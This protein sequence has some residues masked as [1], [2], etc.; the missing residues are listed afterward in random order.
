MLKTL[1]GA[2]A[3]AILALTAWSLSAPPT[4]LETGWRY[5]SQGGWHHAGRLGQLTPE[6]RQWATIAWRYFQNNTQPDTGLVN[7][8]DNYPLT[9]PAQMGDTLVA[10]VAAQRLG[11]LEA[12]EFDRRLSALLATLSRLPLN[13]AGL[14]NRYYDSQRLTMVNGARQ[15]A[16]DGWSAG[17][18]AR[19]LLGLRLVTLA[20]PQYGGFIDRI[21]MGWNFCPMLT[22]QGALQDG[23]RRQNRW[24][25][26]PIA[27]LAQSQYAAAAMGLW[28]FDAPLS[29]APPYKRAIIGPNPI[30]TADRDPRLGGGNLSV[31]S[32]PYLLAGLEFNW[33]PPGKASLT[34]QD[35]RSRAQSVYQAQAWRWQRDGI[36][37]A[38]ADYALNRAP[39]RVDNAVFANGYPWNVLTEGGEYRPELALTATRALFGLWVLWDSPYTDA[40]MQ[41]GRWPRDD[42]RGWYEGRFERSGEYNPVMTLSTNAMVLESLL[43]KQNNGPLIDRLPPPGYLESQLREPLNWPRRCLPQEGR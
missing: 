29:A 24:Q 30:A 12:A 3:I 36:L 21:V 2:A 20:A 27:N 40:L 19:L 1:I 17:D 28:G 38:R 13:G 18:I 9:T 5:L 11:L 26:R 10:L 39:W 41:L 23:E 15:P 35:L 4:A 14:P 31:D 42:R 8:Q 6:E 7:G 43:Y 32:T 22:P 25:T 34:L 16:D 33:S 37:T